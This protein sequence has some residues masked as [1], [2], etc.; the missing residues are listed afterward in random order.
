MTAGTIRLL[1]TALLI[2]VTAGTPTIVLAQ[3]RTNSILTGKVTDETGAVLPGATITIES[4]GLV[5]G[6]QTM[7]TDAEGVYRF[8]ALPP[9]IYSILVEMDGFKTVNRT[10]VR[11]ELATTVTIDVQ[12]SVANVSE[13]VTV[14]GGAP[15]VDIKTAAAN[16]TLDE[17]LLQN[18][19]TERFQPDMINLAPGVNAN[20]AFGGTQ[21]SNAL[22]I[23]GVDISDPLGRFGVV[24]LQLQ[25]DRRDAGRLAGRRCRVRRVHGSRRQQRGSFRKQQ[26]GRIARVSHH[27]PE[28]AE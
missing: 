10:D 28:L 25:L 9:E 23:D 11:I 18:L 13:T 12:L 20:V 15:V 19:P 21:D 17:H 5:G 3:A 24:L 4:P 2:A 7:V 22:L 26:M 6:V 16:A 1:A 8:A 27:P 14:V